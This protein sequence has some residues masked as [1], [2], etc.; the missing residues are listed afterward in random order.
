[1]DTNFFSFYANV[2]NMLFSSEIDF[3]WDI[4]S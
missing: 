4:M 1:M 3:K 2:Q